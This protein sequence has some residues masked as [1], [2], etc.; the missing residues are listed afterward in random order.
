MTETENK[1][2]PDCYPLREHIGHK[3]RLVKYA[4]D[5]MVLNC[6]DKQCPDNEGEGTDLME[7]YPPET[8]GED[9]PKNVAE[10]DRAWYPKLRKH[11][12]HPLE[13]REDG[14]EVQ[15]FCKRCSEVIFA[16]K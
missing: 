9:E 6:Y 12:R 15:L 5:G 10:H 16:Q 3:I 13:I 11:Y 4:L 14:E 8:Y 7:C 2:E 1:I